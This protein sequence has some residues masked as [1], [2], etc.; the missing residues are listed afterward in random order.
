[1][2]L[3]WRSLLLQYL[4]QN[5]CLSE[6]L[7]AAVVGMEATAVVAVRILDMDTYATPYD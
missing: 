7:E 3:Q 4:I 5:E 6:V 1:M 2:G